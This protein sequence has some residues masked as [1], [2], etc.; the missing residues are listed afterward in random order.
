MKNFNLSISSKKNPNKAHNEDLVGFSNNL[1]WLLDGATIPENMSI[2]NGCDAIWLVNQI[3][4]HLNL[5]SINNQKKSLEEILEDSLK[6]VQKDFYSKSRLDFEEIKNFYIPSATLTLVRVLDDFIEYLVLGDSTVLIAT[7]TSFIEVTD[8]RLKTVAIEERQNIIDHIAKGFR[9]TDKTIKELHQK[10]VQKEQSLLNIEGGYWMTS[11]E[12]DA[13]KHSIQ[14]KIEYGDTARIALLSDGLTRA[15]THFSICDS[16]ENLL[17][18]LQDYGIE[19][20]IL[21][22][23]EYEKEDI[24]GISFKRTKSSDDASGLYLEIK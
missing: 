20:C 1:F 14:G 2:I 24:S 6:G 17:K 4:Y 22:V 9:Y 16:W 13:A 3:S 23:R 11:I 12:P 5:N 18:Y 21:K 8:K 7:E 19:S 15:Y 10:L